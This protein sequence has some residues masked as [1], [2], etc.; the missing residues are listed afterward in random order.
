MERFNRTYNAE[1]LDFYQC[2]TLNE[3]WEITKKLLAV[4]SCERP[5]ESMN[6]MT[7]E[8]YQ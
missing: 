8:E 7:L 4:N 5:H 1:I 3:V 2:R 6:N